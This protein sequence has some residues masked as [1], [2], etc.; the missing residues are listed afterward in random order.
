MA[1]DNQNRVLMLISFV[2]GTIPTRREQPRRAPSA[3]H[4]SFRHGGVRFGRPQVAKGFAGQAGEVHAPAE[5]GGGEPMQCIGCV[6]IAGSP[7][8]FPPQEWLAEPQIAEFMAASKVA[9][10]TGLPK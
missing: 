8:L 6:R 5:S 4:K 9:S 2:V 3:V 10:S 7:H 1:A